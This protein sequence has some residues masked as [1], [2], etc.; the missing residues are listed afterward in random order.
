MTPSSLYVDPAVGWNKQLT[1]H[2]TKSGVKQ[3][4]TKP[5][6]AAVKYADFNGPRDAAE[7]SAWLSSVKWSNGKEEPWRYNPD[8]T[9]KA[10]GGAG[11][12][13]AAGPDRLV[14]NWGNGDVGYSFAN[15]WK[16]IH[17]DGSA[18]QHWHLREVTPTARR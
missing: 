4:I 16:A 13:K 5:E 12:W 15:A 10:P 1:I 14:M 7:L 6:N 17:Q 2:F 3:E 9:F 11:T 18:T 8:G